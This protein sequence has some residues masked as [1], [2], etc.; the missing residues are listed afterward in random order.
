MNVVP[1]LRTNQN[2]LSSD[3]TIINSIEFEKGDTVLFFGDDIDKNT[4]IIISFGICFSFYLWY[5]TGILTIILHKPI[6]FLIFISMIGFLIFQIFST[7]FLSGNITLENSKMIGINQMIS[8]FFGSLII[9][10]FAVNQF[11]NS[12]SKNNINFIAYSLFAVLIFAHIHVNVK[13]TGKYIKFVRQIKE[14]LFNIVI[15]TSIALV[16]LIIDNSG[17]NN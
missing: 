17:F 7:S 12:N 14:T 16:Y 13:T 8:T 10:L 5:K 3:N 2:V 15:F 11:I 4:L 6:L 9:F 1:T